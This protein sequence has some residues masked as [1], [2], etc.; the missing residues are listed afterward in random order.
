MNGLKKRKEALIKKQVTPSAGVITVETSLG[1]Q[2]KFTFYD[3]QSTEGKLLGTL[4]T[5]SN[6]T[7]INLISETG[8]IYVVNNSTGAEQISYIN[9]VNISGSGVNHD[10]TL[11]TIIN[12]GQ[13][14]SL[15]IKIKS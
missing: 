3:G 8:F 14:F 13:D 12:I 7:H 9:H 2:T 4:F 6:P 10:P 5:T 11:L 1:Y 15:T